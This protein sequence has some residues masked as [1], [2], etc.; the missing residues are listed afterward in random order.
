[1]NSKYKIG[2]QVRIVYPKNYRTNI[3]Y[4]CHE[5]GI[6]D[7]ITDRMSTLNNKTTRIKS[8]TCS[9]KYILDIFSCNFLQ[10]WLKPIQQQIF[11]SL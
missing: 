10:C 2:D 11:T 7:L 6:K 9:G 1:M 4:T 3:M 8:R 5:T